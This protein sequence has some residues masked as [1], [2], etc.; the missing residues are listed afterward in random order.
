MMMKASDIIALAA[1]QIGIKEN[2][3]NSNKVLYNTWFYGRE[4]SG[5]QYAWCVV[6]I[7]WLFNECGGAGIWIDGKAKSTAYVPYVVSAAK[8]AGQWVTKDFVPGD[9]VAYDFTGAKSNPSHVGVIEKINT[10]GT[11]TAIE[12]NTSA[13]STDNGGS[14]MRCTRNLKYVVGAFRP[15]YDP[16]TV[17]D[18]PSEWAADAWKWAKDNQITDGTNPKVNA[19]REQVA[20]MLYRFATKK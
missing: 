6:F 1:K 9:I 16:E 7:A 3:A 8:K 10:D 15:K 18:A 20:T 13:T 2:P 11:I 19:T 14:V 17:A 4:V 5:S 12:G